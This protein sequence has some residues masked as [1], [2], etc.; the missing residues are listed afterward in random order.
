[1][2]LI[3]TISKVAVSNLKS[4]IESGPEDNGSDL[5]EE[6][7]MMEDEH[8]EGCP[9]F[10]ECD[11]AEC[12]AIHRGPIPDVNNPWWGMKIAATDDLKKLN[13][14]NNLKKSIYNAILDTLKRQKVDDTSLNGVVEVAG[15]KLLAR[16]T[17]HEHRIVGVTES[18]IRL[19][20]AKRLRDQLGSG[21][22]VLAGEYEGKAHLVVAVTKDL[23]DKLHAGVLLGDLAPY[24]D[25]KGAGSHDLA[26]AIGYKINGLD[27]VVADAA[28]KLQ[29]RLKTPQF[30]G[31][32][33]IGVAEQAEVQMELFEQNKDKDRKEQLLKDIREGKLD[34]PLQ[35]IEANKELEKI[36]YL[37]AAAKLYLEDNNLYRETVYETMKL[38]DMKEFVLSDGRK[39]FQKTNTSRMLAFTDLENRPSQATIKG[40]ELVYSELAEIVS[41]KMSSNDLDLAIMSSKA[42]AGQLRSDSY[43][44]L[45]DILEERT[46]LAEKEEDKEVE[47]EIRSYPTLKEICESTENFTLLEKEPGYLYRVLDPTNEHSAVLNSKLICRIRY[48]LREAKEDFLFKTRMEFHKMMN[49]ILRKA[50]EECYPGEW[51]DRNAA[52]YEIKSI[53]NSKYQ[54]LLSI[55]TNSID[56]VLMEVSIDGSSID[57]D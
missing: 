20:A 46:A 19:E 16:V 24:I 17:T 35:V 44:S 42:Q 51:F 30:V 4:A 10:P 1:M 31:A 50:Y 37:I 55:S 8:E 41:S 34:S 32:V 45:K 2:T 27:A 57:F 26:Q 13:L 18:E 22:V 21:V 5:M 6:S 9:N 40:R 14:Q 15:I 36:S 49:V 12:T 3:N 7:V 48:L 11:C 39:V 23:T 54:I 53:G 43:I 28:S 38:L 56:Y 29:M 52:L 25:G 33:A 47:L